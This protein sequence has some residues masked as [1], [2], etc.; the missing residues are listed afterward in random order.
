LQVS[1]PQLVDWVRIG[2]LRIGE[3]QAYRSNVRMQHRRFPVIY[4]GGIVLFNTPPLEKHYSVFKVRW[5]AAVE[6]IPL[7]T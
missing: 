4:K 3:V 2:G 6:A 1:S 5:I 7:S